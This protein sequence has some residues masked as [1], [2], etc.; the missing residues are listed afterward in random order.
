MVLTARRARDYVEHILGG[1]VSTD[2]GVF[3]ILNQAGEHMEGTREW[4]YLSRS[5][6]RLD[7]R[8]SVTGTAGTWV[9]STQTLTDTGAFTGYTYVPGDE[10]EVTVA[11]VEKGFY[12]ISA[13][14]D[15]TLTLVCAL[16]DGTWTYTVRTPRVALPSDFS[17]IVSVFGVNG[18]TR[19]T[20][21]TTTSQLLRVD[22][23]ALTQNNF[24]TGY[25][26]EWNSATEKSQP[27]ATL[28]IW[29]EPDVDEFSAL[30]A[31]YL[32]SWPTIDSDD[33]VLPL[34][35]YME[36]LYLQYAR[37]F[38]AGYDAGGTILERAAAQAQALGMLR[39]SEAYKDAAKRD[40]SGQSNLGRAPLRAIRSSSR[41]NG[42]DPLSGVRADRLF[43]E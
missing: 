32:R 40:S 16:A 30:A 29:P 24:V 31:V 19:S 28:R 21:A 37:A 18:Y 4:V 36:N 8:A 10:I 23:L 25:A 39:E 12:K 34:P 2:I 43:Q 33:D 13:A 41:A 35:T 9:N 5:M 38:A 26:L 7:F 1:D 3:D 14:T 17:R 11:G 6:K 20:F 42:H 27:V 22:T 15:N